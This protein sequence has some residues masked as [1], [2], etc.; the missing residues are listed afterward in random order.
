MKL[1]LYTCS[2]PE[3]KFHS[4]NVDLAISMELAW[5]AVDKVNQRFKDV[6]PVKLI[7]ASAVGVLAAL[8][9]REYARDHTLRDLI[10]NWSLLIP[11]VRGT[12]FLPSRNDP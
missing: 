1:L 10:G 4:K 9:I 2:V 6:P 11:A 12:I 7:G 5:R 8:K 3:E